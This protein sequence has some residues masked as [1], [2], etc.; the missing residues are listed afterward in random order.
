MAAP[1]LG[2]FKASVFTVIQMSWHALEHAPAA[3]VQSCTIG[4]GLGGW[5][6][7]LGTFEFTAE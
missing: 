4:R 1:K 6:A 2:L 5:D 3:Q 7:P